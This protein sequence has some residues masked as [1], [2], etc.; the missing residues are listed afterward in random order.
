MNKTLSL[1]LAAAAFCSSPAA[2]APSV[3]W[4]G[5]VAV[6]QA[7]PFAESLRADLQAFRARVRAENAELREAAAPSQPKDAFASAPACASA[8][9]VY[10]RAFSLEE[11]VRFLQ[12]CAKDLSKA[13]G[14]PVS[15]EKG[16]VDGKP[17]IL[18]G[19]PAMLPQESQVLSDL[20]CAVREQRKGRLLGLPASV[21]RV[22]P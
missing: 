12:P 14:L 13:Y 11:A 16:L 17:G 18:V 4:D 10:F 6:A 5:A 19:V 7:S 15:I 3:D 20:D 8:D 22:K 9:A 21:G 2:A 1:A